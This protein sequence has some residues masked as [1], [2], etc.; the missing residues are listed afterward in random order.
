VKSGKVSVFEGDLTDY[1]ILLGTTDKNAAPPASS[2]AAEVASEKQ[3]DKK[4]QRQ[5]SAEDREKRKPL[6]KRLKLV[7]NRLSA[8]DVRSKELDS[9]LSSDDLYQEG[10]KEKLNK[11]IA[12]KGKLV[13][14]QE[15]LEAEWLELSETLESLY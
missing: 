10:Q 9:L 7:E 14:E 6:T 3:V 4:A 8:I 1:E 2:K 5:Q 11:L 13:N 15:A 12:E